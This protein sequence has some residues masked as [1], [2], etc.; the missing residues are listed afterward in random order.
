MNF[1]LLEEYVVAFVRNFI[2]IER[3]IF[4]ELKKKRKKEGNFE[5]EE[6][7]QMM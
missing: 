5:E 3:D 7:E 4:M 2:Y 1:N 6:D